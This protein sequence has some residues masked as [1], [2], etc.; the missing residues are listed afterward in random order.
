[1]RTLG[2]ILWILFGGAVVALLWV[3]AGLVCCCTIVAIPIGVQ[4]FKFAS[5][6]FWP[7][8]REVIT[9]NSTGNFLLNLI[10]LLY[11]GL[12]LSIVSCLFGL[13]WCITIVGIPF[14]IQF[15]KFAHLALTPFGARIQVTNERQ[16]VNH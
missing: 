4:C 9:S 8:G 16:N 15:F 3:V 12:E 1:M 7:F 2:N 11:F 10:W 6:T 14:G 5:I 13:V